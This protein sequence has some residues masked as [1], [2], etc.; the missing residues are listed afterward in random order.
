MNARCDAEL[1]D[2]EARCVS[3]HLGVKVTSNLIFDCADVCVVEWPTYVAHWMVTVT[4]TVTLRLG[5]L[6][7][8]V[9]LRGSIRTRTSV[10]GRNLTASPSSSPWFHRPAP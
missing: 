6:R 5:W 2:S 1:D 7:G 3:G 8:Y 4:V 9:T 10:T